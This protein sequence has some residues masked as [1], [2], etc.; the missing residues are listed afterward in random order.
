MGQA[1]KELDAAQA[2]LTNFA[3][4]PGKGVNVA[5][6]DLTHETGTGGGDGGA[7]QAAL[8]EQVWL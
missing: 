8:F 3:T 5:R 4:R 1:K 6:P 2:A 7:R